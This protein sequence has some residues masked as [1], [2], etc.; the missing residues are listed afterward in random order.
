MSRTPPKGTATNACAFSRCEACGATDGCWKARPGQVPPIFHHPRLNLSE[1]SDDRWLCARCLSLWAHGR[2]IRRALGT[3]RGMLSPQSRAAHLDRWL[4]RCA[5][6]AHPVDP[7]LLGA[8]A[9]DILWTAP[10]KPL[11]LLRLAEDGTMTNMDDRPVPRPDVLIPA[12]PWVV[13][14]HPAAEQA[15][16]L[17]ADYKAMP[18]AW[19]VDSPRP[20]FTEIKER[21][22]FASPGHPLPS[23]EWCDDLPAPAIEWEVER[24]P[25]NYDP[26]I[27]W[28]W[29]AKFP[30]FYIISHKVFE[31]PPASPPPEI[32]CFFDT[33][34]RA[35]N[36]DPARVDLWLDRQPQEAL[37]WLLLKCGR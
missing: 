23:S 8:A 22:R 18:R 14:A 37:C 26:G 1:P 30:A 16:A 20:R 10:G 11:E 5:L 34:N 35:H 3:L 19:Q 28:R 24:V 31:V 21:F 15:V 12:H 9:G 7:E 27:E 6:L 25:G 36:A 13:G 33:T 4:E 17:L 32:L 29:P 2:K